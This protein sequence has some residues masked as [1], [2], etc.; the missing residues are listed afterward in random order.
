MG[1]GAER[2][3]LEKSIEELR[4]IADSNDV[5]AEAA[6]IT[7]GF[8]YASPGLTSAMSAISCWDADARGRRPR[9]ADGRQAGA[10]DPRLPVG[11]EPRHGGNCTNQASPAEV[12][13]CARG[14]GGHTG[15]GP[16]V[17]SSVSGQNFCMGTRPSVASGPCAGSFMSATMR[18]RHRQ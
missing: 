12:P 15:F 17:T 2:R 7:A 16:T 13:L 8:W 5:L 11:E 18:V 3:N 1:Y 4:Q 6:G 14:D 9:S 10:L